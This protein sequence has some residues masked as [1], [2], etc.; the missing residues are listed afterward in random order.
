MRGASRARRR[1]AQVIEAHYLF[2][3]GYDDIDIVV[4]LPRHFLDTS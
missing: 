2:G 3:A 4:T 1:C